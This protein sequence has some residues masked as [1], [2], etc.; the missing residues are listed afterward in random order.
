M[1][2]TH[3]KYNNKIKDGR[4]N[5]LVSKVLALQ[6]WRP[7]SDLPE[8]IVNP[9]MVSHAYNPSTRQAEGGASLGLTGQ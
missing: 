9:G 5:N 8:F 4:R 2:N 1:H 7:E 3:L 6:A